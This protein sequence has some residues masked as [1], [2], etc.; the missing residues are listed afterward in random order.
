M[1][2]AEGRVPGS[3]ADDRVLHDGIAEVVDDRRDGED[4]AE[5][6]VKTLVVHDV[7]LAYPKLGDATQRNR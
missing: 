3:L 5:S 6:L 7:H 4:P 1:P 2:F